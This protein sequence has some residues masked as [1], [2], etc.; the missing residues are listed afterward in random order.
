[1]IAALTER[2]ICWRWR[3]ARQRQRQPVDARAAV[4]AVG[5]HHPPRA[6]GVLRRPGGAAARRRLA[7]GALEREALVGAEE[8]D[9]RV[10]LVLACTCAVDWLPQSSRPLLE[11]PVPRL[12]LADRLARRQTPAGAR[13]RRPAAGRASR[14]S[15]AACASFGRRTGF[16]PSAAGSNASA[17]TG[18]TRAGLRAAGRG[19]RPSKPP[20]L[21]TAS[22]GDSDAVSRSTSSS[23]PI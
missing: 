18:A 12:H 6:R 23:R 7:V 22:S 8:E 16:S 13:A 19:D 3:R 14:R 2:A 20:S 10:G 11:M 9:D 21:L 5:L 4:L 15:R 17:V 1:M